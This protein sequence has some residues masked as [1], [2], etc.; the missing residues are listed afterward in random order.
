MKDNWLFKTKII[1]MYYEVYYV[2]CKMYDNKKKAWVGKGEYTVSRF[3][4]FVWS[5]IILFGGKLGSI[6]DLVEQLVKTK[7]DRINKKWWK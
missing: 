3:L 5:D 7:R 1:A 6:K 2:E 4:H